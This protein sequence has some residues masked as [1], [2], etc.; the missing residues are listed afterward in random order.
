MYF[1]VEGSEMECKICK[2]KLTDDN[3]SVA[4]ASENMCQECHTEGK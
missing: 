4:S 2:V 3:T 1:S